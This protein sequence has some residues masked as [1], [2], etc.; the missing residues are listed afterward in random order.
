VLNNGA[1]NLTVIKLNDIIDVIRYTK[2]LQHMIHACSPYTHTLT[3]KTKNISNECI[4]SYKYKFLILNIT[5][6]LC[7]I[8][9][10]FVVSFYHV[11]IFLL[12]LLYSSISMLC[13]ANIQK[14]CSIGISRRMTMR[15]MDWEAESARCMEEVCSAIGGCECRPSAKFAMLIWAGPC[16]L[17]LW[18]NITT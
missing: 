15:D 13:N 18:A 6:P 8:D 1:I 10:S 14:D 11:N 7:K 9:H 4:N 17:V 16:W 3:I 2:R 12:A 5:I